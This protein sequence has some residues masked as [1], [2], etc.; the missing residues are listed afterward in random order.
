MN[1]IMEWLKRLLGQ[2]RS[3]IAGMEYRVNR[4]LYSADG[5]RAAEVREFANG[6]TYL[7]E[8]EW[9]EGT[10]FRPRHSGAVVGPFNSPEQAEQFIVTTE[11]FIGQP[12]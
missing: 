9:A 3:S 1:R 4:T 12:S 2:R 7:L 6:K 10:A 8:S 11:W 5:K